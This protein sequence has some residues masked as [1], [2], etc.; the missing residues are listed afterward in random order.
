MLIGILGK[1]YS[2][3]DTTADYI[4]NKYNGTKLILADPLKEACKILF[5]FSDEQLYGNLKENIDLNWGT[6]PRKILQY[7]GTDIFRNDINKILPDIGSKFWINLMSIKYSEIKKEKSLII[8]S[9]VRFQNE[10]DRI[11]EHGG[12][13][14]KLIRESIK[15]DDKH[16]SENIDNLF[17]DYTIINDSTKND[18]YHKIDTIIKEKTE[19]ID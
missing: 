11:H 9:D 1:K 2:G 19:F 16:E 18:L 3:K 13:I 14:I 10:I 7:L 8:V 17:G 15:N 12:F 6:S 5:N 4:C